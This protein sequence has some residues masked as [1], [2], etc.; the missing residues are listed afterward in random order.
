MSDLM[1]TKYEVQK[2]LGDAIKEGLV[3]FG[4]KKTTNGVDSSL[5]DVIEYGQPK[6]WQMD[7]CIA[8]N[9]MRHERIGWQGVSY[10]TNNLG[11][12]TRKDDIIEQQTWYIHVIM[13]R[14]ESDP[15]PTLATITTEDVMSYIISWFNG[16]G[17]D[18]LRKN[19]VS[20]LRLDP[21]DIIVYNDNSNVYQKRAVIRMNL[22]VPKEF[23]FGQEHLVALDVETWP[24]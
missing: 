23:S 13:K 12:M 10:V 1:K 16:P 4:V 7:R 15:S 9:Y 11:A 19:K 3:K 21:A 24:I 5:F 8:I 14:K 20:S 6:M 22:L 18:T 2:I 17:Q